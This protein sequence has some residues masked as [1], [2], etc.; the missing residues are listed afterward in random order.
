MHNVELL[1]NELDGF[2]KQR[3]RLM[4]R[5]DAQD[6]WHDQE[7]TVRAEDVLEPVRGVDEAGHA[8]TK[9]RRVFAMQDQR[10]IHHVLFG[11]WYDKRGTVGR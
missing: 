9:N 5:I 6:G 10:T 4:V 3:V 8:E 1:A 11:G 7:V 2:A